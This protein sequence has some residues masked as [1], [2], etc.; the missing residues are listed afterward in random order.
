MNIAENAAVEDQQVVGVFSL[1][2][3]REALFSAGYCSQAR[4]DAHKLRDGMAVAG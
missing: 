1:E 4:V 3:S 2:M